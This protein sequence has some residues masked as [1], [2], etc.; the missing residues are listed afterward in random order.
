MDILFKRSCYL[1]SRI[2]NNIMTIKKDRNLDFSALGILMLKISFYIA[3]QVQPRRKSLPSWLSLRHRIEKSIILKLDL[4]LFL[5]CA[6]GEPLRVLVRV[7]PH[8]SV[9]VN[10]SIVRW[11]NIRWVTRRSLMCLIHFEFE[12]PTEIDI[13]R[14]VRTYIF[15]LGFL[16]NRK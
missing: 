9:T 2:K 8:I 15:T 16:K 11:V 6:L 12:Y 5:D 7:W 3:L 1:P 4:A 10:I 13:I 14:I